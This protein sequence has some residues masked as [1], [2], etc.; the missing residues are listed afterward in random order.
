MP[1]TITI[2]PSRLISMRAI[3]SP[4]SRATFNAR[5]MSAS[6]NVHGPRPM[7]PNSL[8]ARDGRPSVFPHDCRA[9]AE[10]F[11]EEAVAGL[12]R[13]LAQPSEPVSR[14]I[15]VERLDEVAFERITDQSDRGIALATI[16]A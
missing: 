11:G 4:A 12:L 7:V 14:A 13:H 6:V 3:S 1:V 8:L 9:G 5:F 2:L 16:A 15:F 10:S